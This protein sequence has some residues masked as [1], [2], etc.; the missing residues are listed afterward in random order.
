MQQ[1]ALE[2]FLGGYGTVQ[3]Q[4]DLT[5]PP[6]VREDLLRLQEKI[7]ALSQT[8][9]ESVEMPERV[10]KPAPS[11][12]V[13]DLLLTEDAEVAS[14][15][16]RIARDYLLTTVETAPNAPP[17]KLPSPT[18]QVVMVLEHSQQVQRRRRYGKDT[19]YQATKQLVG[20]TD[21]GDPM[22]VGIEPHN[23]HLIL[24]VHDRQ[25]EHRLPSFVPA[26]LPNATVVNVRRTQAISQPPTNPGRN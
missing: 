13:Y 24:V 25:P 6:S 1:E 7:K 8:I 11:V 2:Q 16:R 5:S 9:G 15:T 19:I 3:R 14:T 22:L 12:P 10:E 20:A 26:R 21:L 18:E 17:D 23:A 4:G